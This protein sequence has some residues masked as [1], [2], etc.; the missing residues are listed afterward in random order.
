[1]RALADYLHNKTVDPV[2]GEHLGGNML[3]GV[4]TDRGAKTCAGRPGAKGH[5]TIDATTYAADWEIDYLKEDSCSAS[6]NHTTAF[7]EYGLMRDVSKKDFFFFFKKK[8]EE[9]EERKEKEEE[10]SQRLHSL[11]QPMPPALRIRKTQGSHVRN[12]MLL[13]D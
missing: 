13:V 12:A 9:K 11:L 8:E 4:Y 6:G 7:A 10:E 5:E 1:M 2:Q 3:F